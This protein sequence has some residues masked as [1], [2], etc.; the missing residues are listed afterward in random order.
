MYNKPRRAKLEGDNLTV[1][2][3]GGV[4]CQVEGLVDGLRRD[5]SLGGLPELFVDFSASRAGVIRRRINQLVLEQIARDFHLSEGQLIAVNPR[6]AHARSKEEMAAQGDVSPVDFLGD[7]DSILDR[8]KGKD[9]AIDRLADDL[10]K[11]S[12]REWEVNVIPDKGAKY[13]LYTSEEPFCGP[14]FGP[15]RRTPLPAQ[16]LVTLS[17]PAYDLER[18]FVLIYRMFYHDP[19]EA[20]GEMVLY[21]LKDG[22]VTELA[23]IFCW[24]A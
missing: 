9:L 15:G 7:R 20:R 2:A 4:H 13:F 24:E 19:L 18:G 17:V 23:V 21:S 12:Q 8:F 6:T 16:W 10:A 1:T 22:Q 5:G 3:S 14:F 11:L